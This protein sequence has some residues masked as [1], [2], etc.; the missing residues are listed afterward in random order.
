MSSFSGGRYQ[1][2]GMLTEHPGPD[3]I[4]YDTTGAAP[5]V[6]SAVL[7]KSLCSIP[8]L[9]S[10]TL[11]PQGG[12]LLYLSCGPLEGLSPVSDR[13]PIGTD[14]QIECCYD[15]CLQLWLGS[16]VGVQTSVCLLIQP[17]AMSTHQLSQ[18]DASFSGP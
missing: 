18:N 16:S 8:C 10:G 17:G 7:A 3:G 5:H 13:R 14:L 4:P 9:V 2:T 12:P 11:L 15:R 6:A 1:L